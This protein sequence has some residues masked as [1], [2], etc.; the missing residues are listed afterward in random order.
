[1]LIMNTSFIWICLTYYHINLFC[2]SMFNL[3]ELFDHLSFTYLFRFF[4]FFLISQSFLFS[5]HLKT[6]SHKLSLNISV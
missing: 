1:M 2:Q 5:F 4:A 3:I 6:Q